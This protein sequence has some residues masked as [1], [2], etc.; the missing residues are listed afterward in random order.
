[1][2]KEK[3]YLLFLVE[4]QEPYAFML[5]YKLLKKSQYQILSFKSSEECLE[6]IH[7]NPDLILLDFMLPGLSSIKTIKVLMQLAPKIPVLLIATFDD[8]LTAP[9][10]KSIYDRFNKK[11]ILDYLVKEDDTTVFSDHLLT[12]VAMIFERK[13]L[14]R[15]RAFR[16]ML[17]IS[18]ALILLLTT[19][20][21]L[22]R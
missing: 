17:F 14:N 19:A 8:I 9:D 6:S 18:I 3:K 2:K 13:K 15:H 5:K 1:M 7:L 22:F 11:G 12:R 16:K 21:L 20:I 4:N 10:F